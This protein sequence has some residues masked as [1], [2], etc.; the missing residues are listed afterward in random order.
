MDKFSVKT[1]VIKQGN[2]TYG[3]QVTIKRFS[4]NK[5]N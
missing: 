3:S 4:K 1:C 2:V 5:P